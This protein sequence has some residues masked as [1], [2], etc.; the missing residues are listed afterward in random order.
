MSQ[1]YLIT[2]TLLNAWQYQYKTAD[3][4]GAEEF[5]ETILRHPSRPNDAM[6]NGILFEDSI[7]RYL[8]TGDIQEEEWENGIRRFGEIIRGGQLQLAAST[9]MTVSDMDFVLYGKL[10][11]LKAG[12]IYDIKFSKRYQVG[13]YYDS[14]Q[15]PM[16]FEIVPE[17]TEFVYLVFDGH[18]CYTER[19]TREQTKPIA[20]T[21]SQFV[22]YLD[23]SGLM[24][25]FTENW[26]SKY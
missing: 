11:A 4:K 15:H 1:R 21:I 25:V 5:M 24:G 18:E 3:E 6:Q 23:F 10:D 12:T 26:K 7:T 17:A 9:D 20:D 16:Y 14:P 13:K 22:T 8:K 2:Q 19:Y